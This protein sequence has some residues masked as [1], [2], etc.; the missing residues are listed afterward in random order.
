[1][2]GRGPYRRWP[3]EQLSVRFRPVIDQSTGPG[4]D[5][6][7]ADVGAP[8]GRARYSRAYWQQQRP[9]MDPAA[10]AVF[11]PPD[12]PQTPLPRGQAR[13]SRAPYQQHPPIQIDVSEPALDFAAIPRLP[14]PKGQ[15]RFG[16]PQWA[17]YRPLID[18]SEPALEP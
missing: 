3:H 8:R 10:V 2:A 16:R 13:L 11:D 15:A 7:G 9:T 17:Q 18:T 14:I 12:L 1:M 4:F 5:Q 6:S